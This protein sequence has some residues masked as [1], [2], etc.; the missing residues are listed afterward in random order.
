MT[1]SSNNQGDIFQRMKDEFPTFSKTLDRIT[2]LLRSVS[3]ELAPIKIRPED[4][5]PPHRLVPQPFTTAVGRGACG[6]YQFTWA[7]GRRLDRMQ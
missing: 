3:E 1:A 4:W 6:G 5:K 7:D 2:A